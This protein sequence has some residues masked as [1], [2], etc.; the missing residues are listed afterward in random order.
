MARSGGDQG[1]AAE[2]LIDLAFWLLSVAVDLSGP[3]VEAFPGIV[4]EPGED[5]SFE[6]TLPVVSMHGGRLALGANDGVR[7]GQFTSLGNYLR[8]FG[9]SRS[10]PGQPT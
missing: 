1:A 10:E 9:M 4:V 7:L 3:A 5:D 6:E 8:S 2:G